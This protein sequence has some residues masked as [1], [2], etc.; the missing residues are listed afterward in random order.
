MA[1]P[2]RVLICSD[3]PLMQDGLRTML[4]AEPDI[5]VVETTD[6]GVHAMMLARTHELDIILTSLTLKGISGM[7]VIRRLDKENLESPPRVVV[8]TVSD[9]DESLMEVLHAGAAGLLT[10]DTSREELIVA[11]RAVA[12]GHAMLAPQITQRLLNWLRK[13]ELPPE[14]TLQPAVAT[15]TPRERQVLLLNAHGLSTEEIASELSVGV[16]TIRTHTYR[17]R[18]KLHLKDRAQLV[19]FAYR[20]G[21]MQSTW[22]R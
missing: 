13:R 11:L 20:A 16:A 10:K 4:D 15:L 2:L 12:K 17:L 21:L 22:S 18:L 9:T 14:E 1:M 5:K 8:F 3:A 6:S 7:D 19:S